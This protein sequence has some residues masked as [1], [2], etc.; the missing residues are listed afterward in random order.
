M[1]QENYVDGC[2]MQRPHLLKPNGF[3]FWK[4][5]FETY[6]KS[7]D[8]DL[9]QVIKYGDFYYEVEDSETKLMKETPYK[10]LEDGP[11]KKFGKNNEAKMTLYN[12]LPRKEYEKVFVCKT[13]NERANVT[14]IEEAKNLATFPLDEL[15]R[16]LKVYEM[17]LDNDSVGTKITKEKSDSED[18]D[19]HQNDAT[20]LVAIDSQ[21]VVSKPCS[22]NIDLNIIELPKEN[23]KL[24]KFSK[25]F[26]KTLEKL[27]KEKH[28]LED[29][30][31]KLSSKINDLEIEVKKLVNKEVVE[32]CLK[33]VELTQ[34]VESLTSNVSKIQNE[35]LNFSKFKS[36]S[37]ALDDMLSRQKLSQDKKGLGF[38][39]K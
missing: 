20:C 38:S 39:K 16:N 28:A 37:I 18:G 31:S 27:L 23:E 29:K 21:E 33:C 14:A 4:A 19:E 22:Y 6:V 2:S 3:C 8:I 1:A 24:L 26:T 17:V 36:S 15:I 10:L 12:P 32:P 11:K 7:K 13:T 34:E 5:C 25:D 35:A 30:N 9:W